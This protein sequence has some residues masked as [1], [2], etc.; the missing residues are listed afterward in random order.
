MMTS[1]ELDAAAEILHIGGLLGACLFYSCI[2]GG[3]GA[4][5]THAGSGQC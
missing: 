5:A 1:Y 3:I 2:M 4:V